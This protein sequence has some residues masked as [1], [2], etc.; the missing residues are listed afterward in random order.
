MKKILK[1]LLYALLGLVVLSLVVGIFDDK[2]KAK[3]SSQFCDSLSE[4]MGESWESTPDSTKEKF[5]EELFST[6]NDCEVPSKLESSVTMAIFQRMR[7]SVKYPETLE[8]YFS[9][10]GSWEEFPFN[11]YSIED[12]TNGTFTAFGQYRAE[13]NL[14]MKVRGSYRF[15]LKTDGKSVS[16]IE[17]GVVD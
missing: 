1:I 7:A 15:K 11:F 14:S 5:L 6:T 10:L 3:L 13:N 17:G 12:L 8:F 4:S 2:K 9:G 16:I